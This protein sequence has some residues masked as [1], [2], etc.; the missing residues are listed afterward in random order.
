[1]GTTTV[2]ERPLDLIHHED[3][4][5]KPGE[6]GPQRGEHRVV[7]WD[8]KLLRLGVE[9]NFG[10]RQE[11]VLADA[12]PESVE[13][14]QAWKAARAGM[15]E[16]GQRPQF[17]V[18]T[19]SESAAGPE[20]FECEITV[21]GTERQPGRPGGARFG[22][23]VHGILR[24]IALDAGPADAHA[25]AHLQGRLLG[26]PPGEVEAA[27][28]AVVAALRHPLL[29]RA[30][31]SERVQRELPVTFPWAGQVLEGIIDLAFLEKGEWTIVDFKTDDDFRAR[32]S[33][34]EKQ[35]AWYALAVARI[36]KAPV[37]ACLF[38][39]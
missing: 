15:I 14:Y 24:D 34:Y 16:R 1:M 22:S 26:A 8:P 19:P 6:Q 28:E 37:R 32:R 7:W 29:G 21:E 18:F 31:A 13:R 10:L 30:L 33:H 23:L 5:V 20:D 39:V 9:S 2:L 25:L 3:F 17:Q 27:A 11:E 4:S 36:R 12:S 35:I 38:Q